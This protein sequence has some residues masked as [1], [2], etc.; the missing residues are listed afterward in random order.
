VEVEITGSTTSTNP[1]LL[2]FSLKSKV[3]VEMRL[4]LTSFGHPPQARFRNRKNL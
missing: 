1:D 2:P 4:S 3:V